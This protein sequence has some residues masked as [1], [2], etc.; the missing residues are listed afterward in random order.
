MGKFVMRP[1][2]R[3]L[4]CLVILGALASCGNSSYQQ[5]ADYADDVFA[6]GVKAY[7]AVSLNIGETLEKIKQSDEPRQFIDGFVERGQAML[8]E[9]IAE[10]QSE[11]AIDVID[12]E[13]VQAMFASLKA[14]L[15]ERFNALAD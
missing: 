3:L 13:H 2:A 10:I 7:D 11:L 8:S 1:V 9:N 6:G 14:D 5:G 15:L 4:G 12:A